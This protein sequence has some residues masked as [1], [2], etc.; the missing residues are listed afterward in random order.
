MMWGSRSTGLAAGL[1]FEGLV[2]DDL[3]VPMWGG[4]VLGWGGGSR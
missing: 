4:V 3:R 2:D 1:I